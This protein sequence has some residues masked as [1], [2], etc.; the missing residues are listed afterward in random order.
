M[1]RLVGPAVRLEV[2]DDHLI[3]L[4]AFDLLDAG[5]FDA[6]AEGEVAVEREARLDAVPQRPGELRRRLTRAADDGRGAGMILGDEV[7]H[8]PDEPGRDVDLAREA[9]TGIARRP[10]RAELAGKGLHFG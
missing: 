6:R 1:P 10:R 2:G 9:G 3:E 4:E 8:G 5:H 7:L